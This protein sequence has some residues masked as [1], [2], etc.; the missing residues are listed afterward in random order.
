MLFTFSLQQSRKVGEKYEALEREVRHLKKKLRA[1]VADVAPHTVP[2]PSS[3]PQAASD[4]QSVEELLKCVSHMWSKDVGII[5]CT[6]VYKVFENEDLLKCSRKGKKTV[7][8]RENPKPPLNAIK[9]E[10]VQTAVMR[11]C[12]IGVEVFQTNLTI[13]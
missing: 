12:E 4:G 13:F 9:L 3:S 2:G 5:L 7:N 6:L 11:K 1:S 8:S 10:I